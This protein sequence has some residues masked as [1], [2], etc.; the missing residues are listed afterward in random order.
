MIR[1]FGW[2]LLAASAVAQ[3]S[4]APESIFER[5]GELYRNK[6]YAEAEAAYQQLLSQG[7]VLYEVYYNLA[8]SCFK[9]KKYGY[10]VFFYEKALRL[11]PDDDDILFNLEITHAYLKDQ[12][13]VPPDFFLF[14]YYRRALYFF[15]INTLVVTTVI[16]WNFLLLMLLIKMFFQHRP[17]YF[18]HSLYGIVSVFVILAY[19]FAARVYI[20][21]T[22]EEAVIL[23]GVCDIKSEPDPAAS[24]VFILHEGTKVEIRSTSDDWIE[25]RLV[26]GKV[27]WV[28]RGDV[29]TL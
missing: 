17:R 23:S 8:N 3:V 14:H 25:I 12:I 24:T 5:A 28:R 16:L 21:S 4:E 13:I 2:L 6:H 27:G 20:D 26:D 7:N 9:Q 1:I 22:K 29:G 15:S 10:A 11:A 18:N 19:I